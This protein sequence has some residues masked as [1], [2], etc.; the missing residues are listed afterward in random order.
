M[1]EQDREFPEEIPEI[2]WTC[3]PMFIARRENDSSYLFCDALASYGSRYLLTFINQ[4]AIFNMRLGRVSPSV[5]SKGQKWP[6]TQLLF[7]K[8]GKDREG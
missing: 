3:F 8:R 7:L 5:L 1:Q 6:Y 4:I 2:D